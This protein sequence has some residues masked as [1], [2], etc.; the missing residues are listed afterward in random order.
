MFYAQGLQQLGE[1]NAAYGVHA[2]NCYMEIGLTDGFNV[3]QVQ[4]QY[5]VYVFLVVSQV[6]AVGT[7]LVYLGIFKGFGFG[8]AEHFVAFFLI[9][10]L[11]FFVQ[12]LQGIPLLG[13]VR[14]GKDDATVG[15]FHCYGQFGGRCRGKVDVYY[16]PTHAH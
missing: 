15:T 13:V 12:Q 1:D 8:D 3:H 10:E 7:K 11:A 6:F 5:A 9:Q 14:G 2:I 4:R 16:I